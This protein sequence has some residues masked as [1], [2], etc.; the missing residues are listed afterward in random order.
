MTE[1]KR[2][3]VWAHWNEADRLLRA[4]YEDTEGLIDKDKRAETIAM[5]QVHATLSH[6]WQR[7]DRP[8]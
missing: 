6:G 2:L 3:T 5:A 7:S 1:Q 8:T 4:I